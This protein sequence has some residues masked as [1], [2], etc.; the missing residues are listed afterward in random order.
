MNSSEDPA[1]L[2]EMVRVERARAARALEPDP[3]VINGVWGAAW[4]LGF[5]SLW[6]GASDAS[7][8]PIDAGLSGFAFAIVMAASAAVT[9]VHIVR[10]VEG[11]RGVSSTASA[12]YAWAW[13]L[14]FMTL[15][16]VML[17]LY[18]AGV[19][20]AVTELLWPVLSSLIV[21]TLCLA[22]GALWQDRTQYRLG[23]WIMATSAVAAL[24]G[25]PD[26]YLAMATM[27]G[28]GFLAAALAPSVREEIR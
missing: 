22:G 15:S 13:S 1:A 28:G 10:R 21:G 19:P 27:G 7:P 14:S 18:R 17:G 12:M 11:V 3:R 5:L 23:L 8:L 25:Y 16:M 6:S 20:S 2:L 4:L 26:A 24:V 9:I